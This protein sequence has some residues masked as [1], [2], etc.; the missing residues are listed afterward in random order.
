MHE[1]ERQRDFFG[2]WRSKVQDWPGSTDS[3]TGDSIIAGTIQPQHRSVC[4][5]VG[6]WVCVF[7]PAFVPSTQS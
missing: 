6:M 5:G 2:F 3:T 1:T 4:G 7:L